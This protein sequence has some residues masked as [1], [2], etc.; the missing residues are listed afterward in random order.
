[1]SFLD[2]VLNPVLMPLLNKSPFLAILLLSLVISLIIILVYKYFTN[3]E[4]MKRLKEEQKEYQKKMKE[5]KNKPEEM[6]KIQK[7]A[8]KKN[9]DYMKHSFKATLITML[10]V[11]LIFGWMNAHLAYEPIYPG[12]RYSITALFEKGV[13][14]EAEL[15][16]GE[17]TELLSE[18][19]Q[20]INSEVT[21]NLRSDEG[22]HILTVKTDSDEQSKKVLIT[23]E[24]SYEEPFSVFE[25]SEIKQIK[26]DYNKLQPLRSLSIPW[27]SSWGWLG[28]YIVLSLIFSIGL[29]KLFNVY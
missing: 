14:G 27:V 19:K 21:W 4:E 15:I 22:E 9:M 26:I 2:P 10:P 5:L 12:E 28:L 18:P 25:H 6:M 13:T 29:R 1:M 7:E 17:G 16:V 23:K 3:Q 8:M 11:I 24:L 20:Q